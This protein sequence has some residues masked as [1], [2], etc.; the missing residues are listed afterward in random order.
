MPPQLSD[1]VLWVGCSIAVAVPGSPGHIRHINVS[2]PVSPAPG[3]YAV[4]RDGIHYT[5]DPQEQEWVRASLTL[6]GMCVLLSYTG[7]ARLR[8]HCSPSTRA[9][10]LCNYDA[11]RQPTARLE[12][13][14]KLAGWGS[15]GHGETS[16]SSPYNDPGL[17][18]ARRT[19]PGCGG[20][21]RRCQAHKTE[22]S[23]GRG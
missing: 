15:E 22:W 12:T 19:E 10:C 13:D 5:A 7:T 17:G 2:P 11:I 9:Y 1:T 8:W 4:S 16:R 3:H 20:G 23:E 6:L 14:A 18:G 21:L